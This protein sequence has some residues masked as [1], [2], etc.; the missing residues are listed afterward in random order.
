MSLSLNFTGYWDAETQGQLEK[1]IRVCVGEPPKD[2]DWSVSLGRS[3][4]LIY[5]DV[6]VK[7][8]H[9]TRSRMFVED[10]SALPKAITDWLMSYPLA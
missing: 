6:R 1:A 10:P 4:S 7:T 5:C 9:Q 8:S 3:I 2:E